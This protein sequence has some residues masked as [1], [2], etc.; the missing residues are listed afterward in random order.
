MK[1]VAL[2]VLAAFAAPAT[3]LR[4]LSVESAADLKARPVMKVV[5]L[6]EDMKAELNQD[7]EDDKKVH[8]LLDCW[9]KT[10]GQEKTAAIEEAQAKIAQ[11]ESFLGEA[12]ATM[13][14]KKTKRDATLDEVDKDYNAKKAM[15]AERMEELQAYQK[16]S[17]NLKE[18]VDAASGALVALS[19]HADAS[20]TL[21]QV[22]SAAALLQRSNI[23]SVRKLSPTNVAALKAFLAGAQSATSFLAIPGM[24]S[25]APQSGQITGILSQM[26]ED[27]EKDLS[28]ADAK[29]KQAVSE[30]EALRAAKEEEIES[31]RAMVVS[32]D[33][34]IADL[35]SKHATAFKDLE[36]TQEQLALDQ[37][38][39]ATLQEKC[40]ASDTEFDQRVKDRMTEIDA[41]EDTIKILNDDAAFANFD[42]TTSLVQVKSESAE[43]QQRRQKAI[44]V[45]R[46]GA[47]KSGAPALAMLAIRAQLDAFTKVKAEI[48]KMVAELQQQQKDEV[49][50]RDWCID[51]LNKNNRS[52]EEAYEKKDSL[53][54]KIADLTKTIESLTAELADTTKNVADMQEQMKR[55]GETREAEN[56]DF[57]QTMM[58]QRL[59]QQ[60]LSKALARMKEVYAFLQGP[61][62]AHTQTSAT[63]TDPGNGP[64]AF[65]DNAGPN[66]GGS[67][68]VSMI[69]EVIA[70]SKKMEDDAMASE[71]DGQTAYENFMKET[72]KAITA[73]AEKINSMTEAKAKAEEEKVLAK[74]D[75]M[76]TVGTLGELNAVSGDLHKSC[77]F[78]LKNFEAR[79]T[80]RAAEVDSLNEAKAIL[81]GA[82]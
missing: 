47:S 65:K 44:A 73:A 39:L 15:E 31:G 24:Q 30:F 11:L 38:F 2:C 57:Q 25:Y 17:A 6:L 41:V 80:A 12:A 13:A 27:F 26:K 45:L 81:S 74:D 22:K 20:P 64:A 9:C 49:A 71:E 55:A 62:A 68:V 69:E 10:G 33:E 29:E 58:D 53:E 61:G 60:I 70:D 51:E 77:D 75:L 52:T 46:L 48:D 16:E 67:K 40:A 21:A 18:A 50:H 32:L 3:A 72:N 82:K 59:T 34:E 43:E 66:A 54:T 5:R 63:H 79:Q 7:L 36:Q 19:K 42:K 76:S 14:E 37:Q 8:E 1:A 4:T 78:V 35:K 23:L 56:G 28:E